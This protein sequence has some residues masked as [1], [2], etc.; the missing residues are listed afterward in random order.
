MKALVIIDMQ[1]DFMPGGPLATKDADKLVPLINELMDHFSLVVATKDW[2]PK[3]HGSF[4]ENHSGKKV[5]DI[6]KL[7]GVEQILWPVHCVEDT[8]GAEFVK[9]LNE[10][11]IEKIFYK[12]TDPFIDSYSA[13]F[14]NAR[15]RE[16]GLG[17]YLRSHDVDDVTF[18]G[19]ATD[20]CV[21]YSVLDALDLGFK[22]TVVQD[23]CKAINLKE[24]DEKD[25]LN[26]MRKRGALI[27]ESSDFSRI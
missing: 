15:K 21:L 1:N 23:G 19:V 13:F 4:A 6:I 18:V 17:D 25:A 2:H 24:G 12:G 5:G 9:G 11:K 22:V 8:S 16:T 27:R 26:K 10:E 20:Y 3:N 7:G 14:D